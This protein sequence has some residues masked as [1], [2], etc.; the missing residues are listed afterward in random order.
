MQ[1]PIDRLMLKSVIELAR[2]H[3]E[4]WVLY[5]ALELSELKATYAHLK[6]GVRDSPLVKLRDAELSSRFVL[7]TIVAVVESVHSER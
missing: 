5:S 6:V 3:G 1:T 2:E 7:P 4:V